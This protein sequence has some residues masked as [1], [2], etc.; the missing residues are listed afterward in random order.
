MD[1][2]QYKGVFHVTIPK[3]FCALGSRFIVSGNR[4]T[5]HYL[6]LSK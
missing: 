1:H 4:M 5:M 2:L 3:S 6:I